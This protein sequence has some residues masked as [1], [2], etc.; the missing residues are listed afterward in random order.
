MDYEKMLE[1]CN[2]AYES[3]R[4]LLKKK[5]GNDYELR[6][7]KNGLLKKKYQFTEQTQILKK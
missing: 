5:S 7:E 6:I 1:A 2:K 4:K 3:R